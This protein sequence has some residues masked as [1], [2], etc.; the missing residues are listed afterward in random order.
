M[1]AGRKFV[2]LPRPYAKTAIRS[3]RQRGFG[4]AEPD[5]RRQGRVSD[6]GID[7]VGFIEDRLAQ[8]E[9][10]EPAAALPADRLGDAA[11]GWVVV[12]WRLCHGCTSYSK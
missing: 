7:A 10:A 12:Y 8:A 6:L 5:V 1:V 9:K 3:D 11:L 2:I 4:L